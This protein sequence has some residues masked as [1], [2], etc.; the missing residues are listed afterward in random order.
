MT[1]KH[2]VPL[3]AA[4]A[5]AIATLWPRA[6]HAHDARLNIS[7]SGAGSEW[8]SDA[9]A[10]GGLGLGFRFFDLVGIHAIGRFG[11]GTV[12]Q[13]ML[14]LLAIGAQIWGRIGPTRPYARIAFIHQHEE[15][16]AAVEQNI[17]GAIFGVGDGIRHRGGAEGALG[18][19]WPFFQRLPWGLFAS[20]ELSFA[21]FPNSSG[22]GWYF[23]GSLGFGVQYTL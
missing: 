5:I 10:W 15:P 23:L 19:E 3:L 7:L 8:G 13:R 18:V 2:V 21:G 16:I 6:A 17:G 9:A 4:A 14:T 1:R 11:Y 12:D 20:A 22:P